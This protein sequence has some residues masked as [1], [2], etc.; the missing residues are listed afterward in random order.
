MAYVGW[1]WIKRW[2]RDSTTDLCSSLPLLLLHGLLHALKC[3]ISASTKLTFLAVHAGWTVPRWL[4]SLAGNMELS[5]NMRAPM[6]PSRIPLQINFKVIQHFCTCAP[7][8]M[9]LCRD[10]TIWITAVGNCAPAAVSLCEVDAVWITAVGTCAPAAVTVRGWRCLN[11]CSRYLCTCSRV[12]VQ[13]W[14]YLNHCSRYFCTCSRVTMQ[15]WLSESQQL[16]LVHLQP[17]HSARMTLCQ[18]HYSLYLCTC[19][20]VTMQRWLSESLQSV[21]VHLQPCPCARM[22]LTES[23]QSVLVHLQLCHSS[24]MTLCQNHCSLY[25]CTCSRV[26]VQEWRSV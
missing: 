5:R 15:G 11:H 21:L 3:Q 7:A 4:R 22:T 18:N 1:S 9:F 20:R 19:S 23:L 14:H 16:V 13:G 17:C 26:T 8:A 10:N 24:R 2:T 6:S 25:L 12:P